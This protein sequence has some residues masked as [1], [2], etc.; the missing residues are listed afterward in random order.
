MKVRRVRVELPG[1]TY[2]ALRYF[3][4]LRGVPVGTVMRKAVVSFADEVQKEFPQVYAHVLA[5]HEADIEANPIP[6]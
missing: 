3:G 5:Q 4:L 6:Y 1:E 2:A